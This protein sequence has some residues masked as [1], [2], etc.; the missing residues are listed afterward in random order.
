MNL[1]SDEQ[2]ASFKN[3]L[4][5]HTFFIISAHKEPDGDGLSSCLGTA[6]LLKALNKPCHLFNAGPFKRPEL[7]RWEYF[8]AKKLPPFRADELK[9]AGLIILDCSEKERLGDIN[10]DLNIIDTFIIDHHRTSEHCGQKSIIDTTAPSTATLVQQ[11]YEKILPGQIAGET[12]KALFFGLVADTGFFRFI[13]P[14]DGEV[15]RA[16]GR[17][18]DAGADPRKTYDDM[19]GGKSFMTRK[20][21]GVMLDRAEQKFG[22]RV[23]YTYET[24][25]DTAKWG[26]DGRD[27]DSLYQ[28]LLSVDKVEAVVFVREEAENKCTAGLRSRGDID[29]SAIAAKFGG[30]GHKNAAGLSVEEHAEYVLGEILNELG[31]YFS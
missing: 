7:R 18:V 12:A 4:D 3:F 23:I 10:I 26:Q 17:L 30:G 29:V 28:L 8:F 19:N 6:A 11:I 31:G 15:F 27:S 2:V 24:L 1:I 21:L 9:R 25:Q 16:G 14:G 22:G 5:R 20:L 13:A